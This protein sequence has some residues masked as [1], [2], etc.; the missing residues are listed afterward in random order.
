MKVWIKAPYH[1][2]TLWIFGGTEFEEN[3]V[4]HVNSDKFKTKISIAIDF[5]NKK[6]EAISQ[7]EVSSQLFE[8]LS[9]QSQKKPED[10]LPLI[11]F[12]AVSGEFYNI[13]DEYD[14]AIKKVISLIRSR[15]QIVGIADDLIERDEPFFWSV[16]NINFGLLFCI[17]LSYTVLGQVITQDDFQQI[18]EDLDRETI[19]FFLA[20]KFLNSALNDEVP[21]FKILDATT[22]AELAI[23]EFLM[24]KNPTLE[25]LLSE[26]PSPP[27]PKLYGS[28]LE[29]YSSEN[30]KKGER[31]PRL[32]ILDCG[33]QLRNKIVHNPTKLDIPEKFAGFYCINVESAICHLLTL[34]YPYDA[35]W[36]SRFDNSYNFKPEEQSKREKEFCE[37]V[38]NIQ[39][40][41]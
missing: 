9:H 38:K 22:A 26:L 39:K 34:L 7:V 27:L 23:K 33:N 15:F 20:F 30:E 41:S 18:Q 25:K 35:L 17:K 37:F 21:E 31:S 11:D 6:I 40:K 28:I 2:K 8:E 16:D 1:L 36:K 13:L 24:R 29:N 5:K 19:P 32:K 10:G 4:F 14:V 12:S 3:P